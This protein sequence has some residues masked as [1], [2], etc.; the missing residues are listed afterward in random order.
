MDEF[1][2]KIVNLVV[3]C[4]EL[5]V[6]EKQ[7]TDDTNLIMELGI[8]S[9]KLVEFIVEIETTFGISVPDEMMIG[10]NFSTIKKTMETIGVIIKK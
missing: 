9:L 5:E 6:D 3:S 10:E 7:L 1:K 2:S 4:S 8:D